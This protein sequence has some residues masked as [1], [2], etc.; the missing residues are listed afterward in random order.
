MRG[1]GPGADGCGGPWRP[2]LLSV[3]ESFRE[4]HIGVP[5]QLE[6][7]KDEEP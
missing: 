6:D 7:V 3:G 5:G 2:L 1:W 4:N